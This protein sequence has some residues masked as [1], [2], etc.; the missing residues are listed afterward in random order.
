M[1]ALIQAIF[2]D[3][4]NTGMSL[5]EARKNSLRNA[6]FPMMESTTYRDTYSVAYVY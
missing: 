3:E 2:S 6:D 4:I 1:L 5:R